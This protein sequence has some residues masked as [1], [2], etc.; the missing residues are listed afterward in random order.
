MCE[1]DDEKEIGGMEPSVKKDE[2]N[3][4]DSEEEEDPEEEE[5]LEEEEDPEEEIPASSSLH[6]DIDATDDYLRFIEDLERR[7]EHSPLRSSQ[8]SVP[9]SPEE[10][11]DRQSDGHNT[12]SYN[13]SGVWQAPSSVSIPSLGD[14]CKVRPGLGIFRLGNVMFRSKAV[15]RHAENQDVTLSSTMYFDFAA[16]CAELVVP[17]LASS[18]SSAALDL[19]IAVMRPT[20]PALLSLSL[21]FC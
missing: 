16:L 2:S 15:S 6:M 1:G 14:C 18:S 7:P 13:L 9:D 4:E 21:P 20:V 8:A 12:S 19:R 3:E 11:S 17:S 10:A 5:G